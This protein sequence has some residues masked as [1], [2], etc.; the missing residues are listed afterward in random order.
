M[1]YFDAISLRNGNFPLWNP[2]LFQGF[3]HMAEGQSGPLYIGNILMYLAPAK[4]FVHAYDY[5][6]ILHVVLCG[7]LCYV[8][9]RRKGLIPLI[10]FF[11]SL[12]ITFSPF[13]LLHDSAPSLHQVALFFPLMLMLFDASMKKPFINIVLAS[14]L[15][16]TMLLI[17]HVQ[18]VVYTFIA[19]ALYAIFIE[20]PE[21][22]NG[23]I[24]GRITVSIWF[25]IVTIIIGGGLAALQILP[26]MELSSLSERGGDLSLEF[27]RSGTWLTIPRLASLYVIPALD[28]NSDLLSYGSSIIYF[29]VLPI[30]I[31]MFAWRNREFRRASLPW[32]ICFGICYLLGMGLNNPITFL[33]IKI[34]PF[35]LFRFIGRFAFYASFFLAYPIAL[36]LQIAL[37]RGYEL[38]RQGGFW[39]NVWRECAILLALIVLLIIFASPN[40]FLFLGLVNFIIQLAIS[41]FFIYFAIKRKSAEILKLGLF[42]HMLMFL[43]TGFL[44]S[45]TTQIYYKEHVQS[46]RIF[47][48]IAKH[49]YQN[50]STFVATGKMFILAKDF[51][52][53]L[54]TPMDHIT[55]DASGSAG[56]MY[57]GVPI[58]N[59]YT[60]LKT[61]DRARVN[62]YIVREF[63]KITSPKES[64]LLEYLL[65]DVLGVNFLIISGRDWNF[66]KYSLAVG[67]IYYGF[68]ENT[69]LYI[70]KRQH[71]GYYLRQK[72]SSATLDFKVSDDPVEMLSKLFEKQKIAANLMGEE[73]FEG[74]HLSLIKEPERTVY[75][76]MHQSLSSPE[77]S[78][79]ISWDGLVRKIQLSD[80]QKYYD[81]ILLHESVYPGWKAYV[82]G[83]PV[84]IQTGDALYKFIPFEPKDKHEIELRY[85]PESFKR[86]FIISTAFGALWIVMFAL[87]LIPTRKT[88][89]RS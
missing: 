9:F 88:R 58:V 71:P 56:I 11:A 6:V 36:A 31:F 40:K 64:P 59:G 75:S 2:L 3:P 43:G 25:F 34:P 14:M 27:Y 17:G 89:D 76:I 42:V 19:L 83:N 57:W 77:T 23:K 87:A 85:F 49:K 8:F 46:F 73:Y 20:V 63:D 67:P 74:R 66:S 61:R 48:E 13:M 30:L 78:Y 24:L 33:L 68:D 82:D 72:E 22:S 47:N 60:P 29:G 35:S 39:R 62:D 53:F 51:D 86:G 4:Y 32:L 28:R 12:S 26:T 84:D 54:L 81:G 80:E 16:A 7:V 41:L 79:E 55:Y 37:N 50:K 38:I 44:I 15:S 70:A 1:K 52:N 18:M 10:A 5:T 21:A 65:Y 69:Y 45:N